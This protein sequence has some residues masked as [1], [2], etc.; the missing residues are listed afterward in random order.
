MSYDSQYNLNTDTSWTR[1]AESIPQGDDRA[2]LLQAARDGDCARIRAYVENGTDVD[3]TD[4]S[5]WT[6]LF[7]AVRNRHVKAV[8]ELIT[9][10]ADINAEAR[11]GQTAIYVAVKAGSPLILSL[12]SKPGLRK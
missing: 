10:G 8:A 1:R 6:P 2:A 11:N 4:A 12:L 3:A 9:L 7:W 5:G